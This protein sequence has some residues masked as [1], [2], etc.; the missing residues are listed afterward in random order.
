MSEHIF[1]TRKKKKRK[2]KHHP[3]QQMEKQ[4]SPSSP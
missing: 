4:L 2:R 1:E 3:G